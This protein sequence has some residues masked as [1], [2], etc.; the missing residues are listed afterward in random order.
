[1]GD[2]RLS[3]LNTDFVNYAPQIGAVHHRVGGGQSVPIENGS[4][5]ILSGVP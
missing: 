2:R 3:P 4:Q 1:M 5:S